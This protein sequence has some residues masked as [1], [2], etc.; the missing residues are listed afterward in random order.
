M[1]DHANVT[2]ALAALHRIV[3]LTRYDASERSSGRASEEK[4]RVISSRMDDADHLLNL[5]LFKDPPDLFAFRAYL[6]S[7]DQKNGTTLVHI[8][9]TYVQ[10][11]S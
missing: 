4:L 5:L 7:M 6:D 8:F 11:H 9:D 1:T 3:I 2:R 10:W